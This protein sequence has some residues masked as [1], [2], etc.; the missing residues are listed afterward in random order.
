MR[1]LIVS[2]MVTV[3][4]FF[5][6]PNGEIDWHHVDAE[7]NEYAITLLDSVDTLVFGRLTYEIMASYWPTPMGL[8][9]DPEVAAKMNARSKVVFS[10]TLETVDWNN[11]RLIK[12]DIAG[13][14]TS[15]KQQP[16]K[17]MV[18]FGSG[19][20]VTQLS[21]QRVI[22]EYRLIVNSIALGAGKSQFAGMGQRLRLKLLGAQ[23]FRSGNVLLTYEPG[24]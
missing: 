13:A 5:S 11:S 6:G 9:D 14:M 18:I 1:K 10:R 17:D 22:D 15:M 23:A 8:E 2:N 12:D 4:G 7:F 21:D 16:G 19:S 3:D 20:I 24:E